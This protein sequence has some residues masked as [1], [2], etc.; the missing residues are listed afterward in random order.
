M[1]VNMCFLLSCHLLSSLSICKN[2]KEVESLRWACSTCAFPSRLSEWRVLFVSAWLGSH[3]SV[4][5]PLWK[6][7]AATLRF[8]LTP[9]FLHHLLTAP[10]SARP[11]SVSLTKCPH[12]CPLTLTRIWLSNKR[13]APTLKP[14]LNE[15]LWIMYCCWGRCPSPGHR[16]PQITPGPA[17]KLSSLQSSCGWPFVP[18]DCKTV[19]GSNSHG[20]RSLFFST[21]NPCTS[22]G[23]CSRPTAIFYSRGNI[24]KKNI[25]H[26]L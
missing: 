26:M 1:W 14:G 17:M 8:P 19:H 3:S 9:S 16:N 12:L 25:P 10:S 21:G 5:Y 20:K 18:T 6:K 13:C 15:G 22:R 2:A 7:E 11:S 4:P 23:I 24:K